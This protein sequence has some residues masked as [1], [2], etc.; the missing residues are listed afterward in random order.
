M[1]DQEDPATWRLPIEAYLPTAAQTRQISGARDRLIDEC[2]KQSGFEEWK[3][4][5]DLPPLG[6]ET[7]TDWRY[8]IHDTELA[9]KRGYKPAAE[10]QAA[11]DRAM[12]EGAVDESGADETVLRACVSEADGQVPLV[13]EDS[14]AQEVRSGSYEQSMKDPRVVAAFAKWSSCM[15][16]KGFSYDEPLDA[17]DD[18]RFSDPASVTKLEIATATADIACREQHDVAQ[19]WFKSEVALQKKAISQ[20][21][22]ALNGLKADSKSAVD[23]AAAVEAD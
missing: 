16:E 13:A 19:I 2:M 22:V 7:L 15:K 21:Q 20:N 1:P 3:P 17:S 23:K 8:G 6:G 14:V 4:A 11:Y 5:P 12:S 9:S 10:E 18:T